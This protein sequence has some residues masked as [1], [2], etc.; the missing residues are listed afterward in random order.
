MRRYQALDSRPGAAGSRSRVGFPGALALALVVLCTAASARAEIKNIDLSGVG[1][2]HRV[3]GVAPLHVFFDARNTTCNDPDR[4]GVT[5]RCKHPTLPT[6]VDEYHPPAHSLDYSWDFGDPESGSYAIAGTSINFSRNAMHTVVASHIYD[7]PGTY[8]AKLTVR[9]P[10]GSQ[11]ETR[12]WVIVVDPPTQVYCVHPGQKPSGGSDGCPAGA[13]GIQSSNW[14]SVL[15]EYDDLDGAA[16][17]FRRGKTFDVGDGNGYTFTSG[18]ALRIG[19]YGP[20]S[21]QALFLS[22]RATPFNASFNSRDKA[23]S[24]I[25][26]DWRDAN[27]NRLFNADRY[28][29][30]IGFQRVTVTKGRGK[31]GIRVNWKLLYKNNDKLPEYF[32]CHACDIQEINSSGADNIVWGSFR[33]AAFVAST[34]RDTMNQGGEQQE[35][36]VRLSTYQTVLFYGN[37][38]GDQDDGRAVLT[39]RCSQ[40]APPYGGPDGKSD[41]CNLTDGNRGEWCQVPSRW[42]V[43]YGNEISSTTKAISPCAQN[44]GPW[45]A[46]NRNVI[47]DSN[48]LYPSIEFSASKFKSWMGGEAC[49]GVTVRNNIMNGSTKN[50][51]GMILYSGPSKNEGPGDFNFIY[52]N[53][54]YDVPSNRNMVECKTTND[55]RTDYS[56]AEVSNNVA[57]SPDHSDL[58]LN[59]WDGPEV[60]INNIDIEKGQTNPF[61]LKHPVGYTASPATLFRPRQG[62]PLDDTATYDGAFTRPYR[63]FTG[64]PRSPTT[65]TGAIDDDAGLP[66]PSLRP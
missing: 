11:V 61:D 40:Q 10:M 34:F 53:T 24:D 31:A 58:K 38:L 47:L 13:I 63:D 30:N 44:K 54:G 27:S 14:K 48:Y 49:V 15:T 28:F 21:E 51:T 52:N 60:E 39:L 25:R 59:N 41:L 18:R 64:A 45:G 17:L 5:D 4:S 1:G 32:F 35:H 7:E 46:W 22:D 20:G 43:I 8:K 50:P 36:I 65:D 6:S 26:V 23:V 9:D 57:Y 66:A 56:Y 12:D 19:A 3:R 55:C 29:D 16:I 62:G 33:Y 42:A 37:R 2:P